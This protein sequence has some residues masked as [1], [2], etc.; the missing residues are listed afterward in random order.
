MPNRTAVEKLAWDCKVTAGARFNA[1]AR[2]NKREK[3][4]NVL[5][6]VYSA[7]LIC[8]SVATLSLP[9]S[10][11]LIRYASFGG[12]VASILVLVMSMRNYAHQ[13]GV[14]AEQMHRS[15]LE[16]NELKRKIEAQSAAIAAENLPDHVKNYNHILQKWSLNH[17][18]SDFM[19][20]K[21]RHKWE[22]DDICD[23]PDEKL[24]DRRFKES[25]DL[26]ARAVALITLIGVALV[27]VMAFAIWTSI[28][29]SGESASDFT[30]RVEMESKNIT[31]SAN[32]MDAET[33]SIRTSSKAAR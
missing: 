12:I 24:N 10:S 15:A 7:F 33:E 21:Y 27:S 20:Y 19:E 28:E 22:F 14:E 9:L 25:Y 5:V 23:I 4:S 8:V 16:I 11:N 18:Q 1:A 6:S 3:G 32:L 31:D 17:D 13:F 30:N 2:L 29:P 26:S